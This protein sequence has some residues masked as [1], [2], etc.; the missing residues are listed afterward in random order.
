[1]ELSGP[2]PTSCESGRTIRRVHSLGLCSVRLEQQRRALCLGMAAACGGAWAAQPSKERPTVRVGVLWTSSA[3]DEVPTLLDKMLRDLSGDA[4]QVVVETRIGA[5]AVL[6]QH[7]AALAANKVDLIVA[8]GTPAALLA[9]RATKSIPIVYLISGDPV[10]L[11]LAST[12]ARPGANATGVYTMT[13]EVSGKR[14]SLLREAVPHAKRIGLLWTPARR[15]E[16]EY[17][18]AQVA[19]FSAGVTPVPL[20]ATTQEDLS[21]RF[22]EL[23]S[24][25]I[26]A[27]S[28]L[29][30]PLMVENLRMLA[31]LAAQQRVPAIA[32]YANF[33]DLGGLMSYA[34]NPFEVLRI[35]VAQ[36]ARVL[37]GFKPMDL[38]VQRSRNLVLTLNLKAAASLG[39]TFPTALMIQAQRVIR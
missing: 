22:T 36:V 27:V 13:S 15:N 11:G 29:T 30:T 24:L 2:E 3:A 33:T 7:A 18:N 12:L 38:P 35:A 17:N 37:K 34:A 1:V 23:R 14:I 31:T 20:A 8:N 16:A 5:G 26:D 28:V 21:R 10:D 9:Q 6:Q 19:A 25:R 32:S 4:M 39:L